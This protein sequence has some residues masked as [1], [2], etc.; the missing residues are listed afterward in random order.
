VALDAGAARRRLP[1]GWFRLDQ[2]YKRGGRGGTEEEEPTNGTEPKC[3]PPS[4]VADSCGSDS[5]GAVCQ[6]A[7]RS[8]VR[9]RVSDTA[10]SCGSASWPF[11]AKTNDGS[12]TRQSNFFFFKTSKILFARMKILSK[13]KNELNLQVALK[14]ETIKSN[15]K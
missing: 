13:L 15:K 2:P 6:P 11:R 8:G 10:G 14:I 7:S 1:V 4:R 12:P 5:Y 3:V 9:M